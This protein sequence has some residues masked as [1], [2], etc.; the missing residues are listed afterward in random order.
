MAELGPRV[1]LAGDV[2]GE[3]PGSD[4]AGGADPPQ[5]DANSMMVIIDKEQKRTNLYWTLIKSLLWIAHPPC[6]WR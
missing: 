2:V 4:K 6:T 3:A 5:A 1:V